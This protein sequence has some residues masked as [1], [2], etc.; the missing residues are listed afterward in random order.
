MLQLSIQA[1]PNDANGI[2][3]LRTQFENFAKEQVASAAVLEGIQ[4]AISD[5]VQADEQNAQD[6]PLALA[7]ELIPSGVIRSQRGVGFSNIQMLNRFL[8]M[9]HPELMR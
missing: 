6:H 1:N 2:E 7:A 9:M 4:S 5:V 3:A 8:F